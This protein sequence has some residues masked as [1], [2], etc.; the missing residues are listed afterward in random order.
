MGPM[1]EPIPVQNEDVPEPK[2]TIQYFVLFI[3]FIS[4]G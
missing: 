2:P 1:T 4:T 3:N